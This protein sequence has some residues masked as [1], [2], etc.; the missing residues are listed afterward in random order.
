MD[1][2]C[3]SRGGD[4]KKRVKRIK[5]LHEVL[6]QSTLK[7]KDFEK[8]WKRYD[9]DGSGFLEMTEVSAFTSD[10]L[11]MEMLNF[12]KEIKE[13]EA[14]KKSTK[15]TDEQRKK[16]DKGSWAGAGIEKMKRKFKSFKEHLTT[17]KESD[18]KLLFQEWDTDTDGKVSKQEFKSA[19]SLGWKK[20]HIKHPQSWLTRVLGI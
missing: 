5:E 20:W 14:A 6:E 15:L 4:D 8:I 7:M 17:M 18:A 2:S 3:C 19:L 9:R 1:W 13:L 16:M 11:D 10:L 12:E